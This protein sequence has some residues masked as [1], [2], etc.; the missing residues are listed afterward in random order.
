[1]RAINEIGHVLGIA[2]IA[3]FVESEAILEKLKAL[4]VD[5]AQGYAIARPAPIDAHLD[6]SPA[7]RSQQTA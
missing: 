5:Y 6:T 3:E 4:G 1:V 2:T 7:V